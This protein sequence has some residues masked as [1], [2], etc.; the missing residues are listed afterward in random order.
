METTV[1]TGLPLYELSID[2]IAPSRWQPRARAFDPQGNEADAELLASVKHYGVLDR[3]LLWLPDGV[4]Y[5]VIA[6]HRRLAAARLAGLKVVPVEVIACADPGEVHAMVIVENLQRAD[7]TAI[8]EARAYQGLI[9]E[10]KLTQKEVAKR[11]GKT[12]GHVSQRLALLGMAPAVQEMVQDRE[13]DSSVAREVAGLPAAL[14]QPVAAEIAHGMDKGEIS[15]RKAVNLVKRVEAAS[16]PAFWA[17]AAGETENSQ[18]RNIRRLVEHWIG[19]AK[20]AGKLGKALLGLD[21]EGVLRPNLNEWD[22]QRLCVACG[23][24]AGDNW[25][26]YAKEQGYTC[27]TCAI[28]AAG[29]VGNLTSIG[30][31]CHERA[32][33]CLWWTGPDDPLLIPM[34]WEINCPNCKKRSVSGG[35]ALC[36]DA[37]CYKQHVTKAKAGS[38]K[39]R[40][41]RVQQHVAEQQARVDEWV[42]LQETMVLDHW[43]AQACCRCAFHGDGASC[44]RLRKLK[45]Y[46]QG[47]ELATMSCDGITVPRCGRFKMQDHHWIPECSGNQAA[48]RYWL[49]ALAC[50]RYSYSSDGG[51]TSWLPCSKGDQPGEAQLREWLQRADMSLG[52]Q[53]GLLT[54]I[55]NGARIPS[56][57]TIRYSRGDGDK[58]CTLMNPQTGQMETWQPAAPKLAGDSRIDP[59]L[60]GDD[61]DDGAMGGGNLAEP[62]TEEESK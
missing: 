36:P 60:Y 6:G 38:D 13:L 54:M 46:E 1:K 48:V 19:K 4:G 33:T 44:E 14:Q 2:Q 45:E 55:A 34:A 30:S 40:G 32:A 29:L 57:T 62:E 35:T 51:T 11:V 31:H 42:K 18:R 23:D 9:E 47:P 56:P 15:S 3:L 17:P 5:E 53:M 22:V 59:A 10:L 21:K 26:R 49:Q 58:T 52:Q 41:R 20:E 24:K 50:R 37:G 39:E 7:L 28:R 12:Q 43:L 61:D 27:K 25:L 16:K 8:D